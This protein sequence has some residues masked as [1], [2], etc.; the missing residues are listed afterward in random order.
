MTDI[1]SYPAG[2]MKL[3]STSMWA[4]ETIVVDGVP[5]DVG[6]AIDGEKVTVSVGDW[7]RTY[8]WRGGESK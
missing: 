5:I 3:T 7:Q 6:I 1:I 4:L 2:T 8:A